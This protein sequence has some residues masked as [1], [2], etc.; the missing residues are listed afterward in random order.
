MKLMS[1]AYGSAIKATLAAGDNE[2]APAWA[3]QG[4]KFWLCC[5]RFVMQTPTIQNLP[6][7]TPRNCVIFQSVALL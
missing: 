6:I 3:H 4:S 5:G 2:G 1:C 7:N